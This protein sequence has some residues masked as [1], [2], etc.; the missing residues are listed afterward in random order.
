MG[1]YSGKPSS[2]RDRSFDY[3]SESDMANDIFRKLLHPLSYGV[4]KIFPAFGM[5]EDFAEI[6]D[7]DYFDNTGFIYDGLGKY[8]KGRGFRKL[9]FWTYKLIS[10]NFGLVDLSKV[11][12]IKDAD[13]VKVIR[14]EVDG[15]PVY[16]CW[17]DWWN[18]KSETTKVTFEVGAGDWKVT[19]AIPNK[20]T[21]KD[22][23]PDDYPEFFKCTSV[24]T[25][26]GAITLTLG[27]K[28]VIIKQ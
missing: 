12:T 16:A 23:K 28:P 19:E 10:E 4:S 13:N 27:K 20:D 5:V 22:I 26:T 18:T 7:N 9:A 11:T 17:F 14:F 21:D 6:G 3:Q 1:S 15:N 8:D 25:S 2:L 24:S